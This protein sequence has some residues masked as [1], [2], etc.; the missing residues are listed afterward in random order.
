MRPRYGVKFLCLVLLGTGLGVSREG[1]DVTGDGGYRKAGVADCTFER[2]P[3]AYLDRVRRHLEQLAAD[4]ER[5]SAGRVKLSTPGPSRQRSGFVND[6]P[7]RNYIDDFIFGKMSQAGIPH[8]P[9]ADDTEFFRRVNLDLTGRIPS[10]DAVRAFL[11]NDSPTKRN[12][13]I[14][15]L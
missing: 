13:V 15:D 12:D 4:T 6:I 9:L 2:D 8:A 5:V 11:A 7:H 3:G 14:R 1:E 10:A